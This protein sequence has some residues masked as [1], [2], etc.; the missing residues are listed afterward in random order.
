MER[1]FILRQIDVLSLAGATA[2]IKRSHQHGGGK[3]WS[4][5]ISISPIRW[6]WVAVRPTG[7]V[8]VPCER[9]HELAK[10]RIQR[11]RSGLSL[12]TGRK[13]DELRIH[14]AQLFIT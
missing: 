7:D 9:G 13:H 12:L 10:P 4:N 14:L 5:E 11:V 8:V 2:V 6:G 3:A 1:G